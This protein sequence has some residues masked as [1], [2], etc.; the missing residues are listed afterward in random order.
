MF[1]IPFIRNELK[2][3]HVFY[4]SFL[5]LGNREIKRKHKSTMLMMHAEYFLM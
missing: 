4:T 2:T 1:T 5:S 3:A